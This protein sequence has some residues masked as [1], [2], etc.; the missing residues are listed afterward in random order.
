M[1]TV[2]PGVPSPS[3]Y[4]YVTIEGLRRTLEG[5]VRFT[6][7][8]AFN[9]PFELLPEMVMPIGEPERPISISFDLQSPRRVPPVGEVVDVLEGHSS[10]D[11]TSRNIV[12]DLN[13]CAGMLCLSKAGNSLLMWSH[14]ADQYGGAVLEFDGGHEFLAGQIEME[15]RPARPKRE[16]ST[17]LTGEPIPVSELCVKAKDW[18][19]EKEVRVFRRLVDC[20]EVGTDPRGFP[21]FVQDIPAGVIK[22]ITIGER[23]SDADVLDV[24]ARVEETDIAVNLAAVADATFGF[25]VEPIKMAT[26]R[27]K[28]NYWMTP[29]TARL[30]G[31][32]PTAMGEFARWMVEHHPLSKVVNKPV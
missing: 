1:S 18:E 12:A 6:Q 8:S 17:Y 14:Y 7:P 25:R 20:R 28:A 11:A 24:L 26:P 13:G 19:Y 15:Y 30:F 32:R 27:S 10:S 2:P 16:L 4:K 5:T 23:T 3:L 9:D 22:S 31:G 21:I 29:R